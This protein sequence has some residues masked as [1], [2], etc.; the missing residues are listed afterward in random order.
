MIAISHY[1]Q[2]IGIKKAFIEDLVVDEKHRN[3]GIGKKLLEYAIKKAKELNCT[4]IELTSNPSRLEA[5]NLYIT[6][7]FNLRETN[8]YRKKI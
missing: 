3:K 7:G 1:F 5:N 4:H 6:H 2:I 8:C